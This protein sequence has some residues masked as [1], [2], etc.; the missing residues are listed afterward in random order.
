MIKVNE[1]EKE[2]KK[3][4]LDFLI[5]SQKTLAGCGIS[6]EFSCFKLKQSIQQLYYNKKN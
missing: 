4:N 1:T 3:I 6:L 5:I 2:M